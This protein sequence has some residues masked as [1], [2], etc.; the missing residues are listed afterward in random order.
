MQ[1]DLFENLTIPS[2]RNLKNSLRVEECTLSEIHEEYFSWALKNGYNTTSGIVG[3]PKYISDYMVLQ[4]SQLHKKPLQDLIWLD[5]CCG[6]GIFIESILNLY[7]SSESF[8]YNISSLPTIHA[9]DNCPEAIQSTNL[10][11]SKVLEKYNLSIEDYYSSGKLNITIADTLSILNERNVSPSIKFDIIIG[12][13]P[14]VRS[15]RLDQSY[16]KNLNTWFKESSS[17]MFDLH[18]Y[19]ICSALINLEVNGILGFISPPSFLKSSSTTKLR[20]FIDDHS[21]FLQFID[22]DELSIFQDASIHSSIYLLEKSITNSSHND[23]IKFS[24]ISTQKE[25][26]KFKLHQVYERNISL[27]GNPAEGWFFDLDENKTINIRSLTNTTTLKEAKFKIYSGVRPGYKQA[28]TFTKDELSHLSTPIFEK[29]FTSCFESKELQKWKTP[30]ID[31]YLL[32]TNTKDITPPEEILALLKPYKET[33]TKRHEVKDPNYW[34]LLRP[35]SYYNI[36]T[37][38]RI[39]YPDICS[40]SKFVYETGERITLD[41]SFTIVTSNLTLLGILNS[42]I[43]WDYFKDHCMSIGN[44]HK[45]GRLRLKK[46]YIERFPIPNMALTKNSLSIEIEDIV[47]SIL[48]EGETDV[49]LNKLNQSVNRIYTESL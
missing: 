1:Q 29:W 33:L 27:E 30:E 43:A 32:C 17:P 44:A 9:Y 37:Q 4:T 14:Y 5:P 16:K 23:N 42:N 31:K 46:N 19:F 20:S 35:C 6:S 40:K 3:T 38:P 48:E 39:V 26:E 2:I 7:L 28:F 25:L 22:L 18:H 41:G 45:K 21:S 13:P 47:I 10:L 34:Y 36:F 11:I 24:Q 15:T 8:S 49:L 12:N